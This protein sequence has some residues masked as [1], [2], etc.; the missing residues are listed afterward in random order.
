MCSPFQ[1]FSIVVAATSPSIKRGTRGLGSVLCLAALLGASLPA[2]ATDPVSP[3]A[4]S[5]ARQ[6]EAAALATGRP[7]LLA[8]VSAPQRAADNGQIL[9]PDPVPSKSPDRF[10]PDP[11]GRAAPL[12][13]ARP[14]AATAPVV[15]NLFEP[16]LPPPP[17]PEDYGNEKLILTSCASR[18][19]PPS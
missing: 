8:A 14:D 18:A 16:V 19:T 2:L 1:P 17:I 11:G 10:N 15:P 3:R 6:T 4:S 7:L 5:D 13:N 9:D 12:T